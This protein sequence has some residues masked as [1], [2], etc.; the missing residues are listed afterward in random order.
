MDCDTE[1]FTPVQKEAHRLC[2]NFCLANFVTYRDLELHMA[3][4]KIEADFNFDDCQQNFDSLDQL[5]QHCRKIHGNLE[6]IASEEL[7]LL[8]N[9]ATVFC[10]YSI[11]DDPKFEKRFQCNQC[12]KTFT[13][14]VQLKHHVN[15]HLGLR[16]STCLECGKGFTHPTHLKVHQRTHDVSPLHMLSMW[17]D[18]CN[19]QQHEKTP[20]NS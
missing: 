13:T 16:P 9:G 8:M 15:I 10:V 5:S 2:R 14:K 6:C 1:I 4:H 19:C 3:S 11:E 12:L 7:V 18:V 20:S 17:I